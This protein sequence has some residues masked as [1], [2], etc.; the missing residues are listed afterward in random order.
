VLTQEVKDWFL[1][2]RG[3]LSE[4]LEAFGVSVEGD[5]VVFDYNGSKRKRYG[6]LGGD[7]D[8]K[9]EKGSKVSLF[10]QGDIKKFTFLVEGETDAMRLKQELGS[11]D[12]GVVAL[13]G[14]LTWKDEFTSLFDNT[15]RLWVVL[16]NDDYN[17][18][19]RKLTE[20]AWRNIRFSLGT[21]AK[22]LRLP[23]DVKDVCEFFNAYDIEALRL[24]AKRTPLSQSRFHLLDLTAEPPPVR[25]VVEDL[26]CRGD[27]HLMIGE[28]GIGKSWLTMALAAAIA[29]GQNEF[30]GKPV[31]EHGRVL[32]FDEEN[33]EDLVYDRFRKLG[34]TRDTAKNIRYISNYGVRLDKR[35]ADNVVEEA[36]DFEPTLIVLDSL[37]RF[38]TEDENHAGA[39]AGLFNGAIKP[40]ARET[41]A[42]TVLIHHANKS[43][44]NSSYRRSR[45]SGDI[46]AS[47]DCGFDVREVGIGSLAVANF[48]SR[49]QAQGETI[50]VSI[51]DTPQGTVELIGGEQPELPF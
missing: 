37:T 4:T 48:K 22:R 31:R 44:S 35:D 15:E 25:W 36:L 40:L 39:M 24:L 3:I 26:F 6:V 23:E 18:P 47:V 43:D 10:N 38:H 51:V 11:D 29:G 42:A 30:L 41:G 33:P 13:P 7:R 49:R 1:N 21:K 14:V 50:Y 28:P 32:Y 17:S 45:G 2:E 20:D 9:W 5:A 34:M 19:A 46:T 8:F 16:D 12:V 27:I